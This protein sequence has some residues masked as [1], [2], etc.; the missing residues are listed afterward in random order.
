MTYLSCWETTLPS[1]VKTLTKSDHTLPSLRY[2][3]NV[4]CLHELGRVRLP[5]I[6][7]KVLV[8][9]DFSLLLS[10]LFPIT[11]AHFPYY[12]YQLSRLFRQFSLA[13]TANY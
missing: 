6:Q 8:F 7:A 10:L 9:F 4:G 11:F 1:I 3:P 2:T 5:S 13:K 12:F